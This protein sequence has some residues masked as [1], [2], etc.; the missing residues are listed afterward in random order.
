[1]ELSA[2]LQ[3]TGLKKEDRLNGACISSNY[4][5]LHKKPF[6]RN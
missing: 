3:F 2:V 6:K 5:H 4:L 1:M